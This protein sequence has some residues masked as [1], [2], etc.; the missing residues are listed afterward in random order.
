MCELSASGGFLGAWNTGNN[1]WGLAV[2][3]DGSIYTSGEGNGPFDTGTGYVTINGSAFISR[4]TP[5][6]SVIM[7]QVFNDTNDNGV[8]DPGET[9]M[10]GVTVYL[11]T[12]NNGVKN[13]GEPTTTTDAQGA[14]S[15]YHLASGTYH[16]REVTPA[17]Y[18]ISTATSFTVTLAAGQFDD[19]SSFGNYKTPKTTVYSN[20]T[21]V[22]TSNKKP[23]AISTISISDVYPIQDLS[24]T[25]NVSNSAIAR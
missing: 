23:N 1:P 3:A 7:G 15:F 4:M 22:T 12:N 6:Q 20:N 14:F 25:L 13:S 19:N 2:G 11:D 17:G 8:M 24:I 10:S 9:P 21:A 18:T 16:V 5:G